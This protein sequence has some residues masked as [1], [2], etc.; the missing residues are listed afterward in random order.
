MLTRRVTWCYKA[1]GRSKNKMPHKDPD[2]IKAWRKKYYSDPKNLEIR[3]KYNRERIRK[4]RSNNEFKE[5]QNARRRELR[6]LKKLIVLFYYSNGTLLCAC[7][8]EW[9]IQFLSL[10]HPKGGGE[11]ERKV[12]NSCGADFYARLIRLGL[13]D[14]Y[15]VLCLNCNVGDGFFGICPHRLERIPIAMKGLFSPL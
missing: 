12:L 10:D 6:F 1:W 7:C 9:H 8:G 4:L 15:Q 13:P 5:K 2:D 3:R 11:E 14:G